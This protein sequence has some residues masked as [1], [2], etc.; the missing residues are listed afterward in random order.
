[1][2]IS[3]HLVEDVAFALEILPLPNDS[4]TDGSPLTTLGTLNLSLTA[5]ARAVNAAVIAGN[6]TRSISNASTSSVSH[7]IFGFLMMIQ[8]LGS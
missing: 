8:S 6:M 1:M 7:L 2:L 3:I 5:S 4:S